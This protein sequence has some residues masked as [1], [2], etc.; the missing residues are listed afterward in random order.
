MVITRILPLIHLCRLHRPIGT[1][2]LVLPCWWGVALS[3]LCNDKAFYQKGVL[4]LIGAVSLRSAGCIVN[5]WFDRSYDR[6]VKRTKN[7]P[8]AA[9]IVSPFQALA[10][11]VG[12]LII[13]GVVWLFLNPTARLLGIVGLGLLLLYPFMKRLIYWPQLILGLA[14]NLGILIVCTDA[15]P[16]FLKNPKV[17]VLYGVGILWT[18]AYDTI[19]AFQDIQDDIKLGLKSTAILFQSNPYRLPLFSYGGMVIG[20]VILGSLMSC[21]KTYFI[22]LFLVF[23]LG[24]GYWVRWQPEKQES[25]DTF[26]KANALLGGLI[27]LILCQARI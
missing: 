21:G 17:W 25:C 18:L 12:C 16:S 11:F 23:L 27:F 19:Y 20:L 26:F 4:F 14:F 15:N 24:G 9:G 7:R 22:E 10:V 3:Y 13:G 5:D 2:L 6:H 8:L 1:W